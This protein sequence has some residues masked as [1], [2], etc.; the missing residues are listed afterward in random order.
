MDASAV[1][2]RA[3]LRPRRR[4]ALVLGALG[5]A[6]LGA[7]A[8]NV[9]LGDYTYTVPDFFRILFGADIPV[10]SYLLME[11]K[12]PRAV[13]AVLV[14]LSFGAGGAI[15]QATLRNPLASPDLV[16]VSMGASAAAVWGVLIAGWQGPRIS[17]LAVA[18]ALLAAAVV[19]AVGGRAGT[20]RIVLVGVVLTFALSSVVHYL[21]SRASLFDV[22]VA[23][24]WLA[25]SLQAAD[26][27]RVRI[28]ALC[29]L[30]TLPVLVVL[31][32]T[33]R[34]AQLGDELATAL[35]TRRHAP[36]LLLAAAVVLVA[37][38]VAAAGP[39]A[40]LGFM[41]GPIAR[42][43]N[44]GRHTVVGAALVGAVLVLVGDYVGRYLIGDVNVPVGLVTGAA[45]AP[46]LLWLLSRG[47]A[48]KAAA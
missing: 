26:W 29:L 47:A 48:G 41:S 8:A 32:P 21:M 37:V 40:F 10:A 33:L 25:G 28:V 31:A 11:S 38:A 23:L 13:L 18:G 9:L 7:F 24:Q 1:V 5:V 6:L 3:R 35:G 20:Q 34:A 36:D 42:A 14:G 27:Q 12:L 43:L 2:H 39:I 17:L 19:R 22:Q 4:H 16:G 46:F 44:A 45:G 15:F 30:L